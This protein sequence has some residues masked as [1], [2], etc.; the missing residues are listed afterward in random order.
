M[1][2]QIYELKIV[3][4][5]TSPKVTRTIQ[6]P[7]S[8]HL[9]KLHDIIQIVMGWQERHLHYFKIGETVY[10][11]MDTEMD[12]ESKIESK[13]SLDF[14][15]QSGV[16]SME[17]TYDFGDDWNHTVTLVKVLSQDITIRYPRCISGKM[18]CPPEDCGGPHAYKM[19]KSQAQTQD[20]ID[21]LGA[22]FDARALDLDSVNRELQ[23]MF[24]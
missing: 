3:L 13:F 21:W 24:K 8:F 16:K 19:I 12:R 15:E 1:Q 17:Y 10:E 11:P 23:K 9:G 6:V 20:I 4:N 2:R 18:A 7:G 22:P 5:D 14:L